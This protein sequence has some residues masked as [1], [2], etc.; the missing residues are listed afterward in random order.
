MR[1]PYRPISDHNYAEFNRV[2]V[3]D[4]WLV[5][6]DDSVDLKLC[7]RDTV[8][9]DGDN[10]IETDMKVGFSVSNCNIEINDSHVEQVIS[11]QI[12]L[13]NVNLRIYAWFGEYDGVS[14]LPMDEVDLM[15]EGYPLEPTQTREGSLLLP[16]SIA[17]EGK[18]PGIL[19]NSLNG[20]RHLPPVGAQIETDQGTITL[21]NGK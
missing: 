13:A 20:N 18:R 8:N 9:Y 11:R 2:V 1:D 16:G 19:I 15:W 3:I 17:L 7:S 14:E 10:W 6:M 12:T 4:R 5:W 21:T